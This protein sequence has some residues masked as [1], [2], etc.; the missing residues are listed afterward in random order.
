[1]R[2]T[3]P[4][5][6]LGSRPLIFPLSYNTVQ[7]FE[8]IKTRVLVFNPDKVV[9]VMCLNDFDFAD[10]SGNKIRYFRK[11]GSFFLERIDHAIKQLRGVDYHV[12]HFARNKETVYSKMLELKN[13]LDQRGIQFMVAIVPIFP[14]S[15]TEFGSYGLAPLHAEIKQFL[16]AERIQNA[17]LLDSFLAENGSPQSY[18]HDIYHPNKAGH[19]VIAQGLLQPVLSELRGPDPR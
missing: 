17:D 15:V 19:A 11:P 14:S 9:Y 2:Q 7:I 5:C 18:S 1:M 13:L 4:D 16:G 12:Y 6:P 10:G 8:L 3:K